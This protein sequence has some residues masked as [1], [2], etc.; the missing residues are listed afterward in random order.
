MK[1]A[2]EGPRPG[3]RNAALNSRP[4]DFI[5]TTETIQVARCQLE[6][7][8]Q[9]VFDEQDIIEIRRL[10]NGRSSWHLARELS[11]LAE[12]LLQENVV[13]QNLYVGINARK[14]PG[15][16]SAADV[17]HCRCLV[18]DFDGVELEEA[19]RRWHVAGL[20]EPSLA[21]LS[22]H[23]AH[24]YMRLQD[25]IAPEKFAELQKRLIARV[26][27]DKS[28]HDP[29]RIMRLPGTW[30]MKR[31]MQPVPCHIV[32]DDPA[33]RVELA[34]LHVLLPAPVTAP[35][36]PSK[37]RSS[38]RQPDRVYTPSTIREYLQV[39][40]IEIK[41]ERRVE[42]GTML[43][44]ARCPVNPEIVS[45]N[46][47]DI[48]VLVGD[49]GKVCYCNKHNRGQAY[50]WAD[51]RRALEGKRHNARRASFP[52]DT[53]PQPI[54]LYIEQAAAAMGCDAPFVA[55]P[56][57][58]ALAT[59]I[60]N[61]RSILI[62]RSWYEP[63]V[64]WLIVVS[65]SGTLKSPAQEAGLTFL[66]KH[67]KRAIKEYQAA[68]EDF[69]V[70][71]MQHEV[72]LKD[73]KTKGCKQ[74]Q[75]MPEEPRRPVCSRHIV[76]DTT[77]EAL[78]ARLHDQ[79]RGL[80]LVR[81]EAA[82]WLTSFD[83][84]KNGRGGDV[85]NWLE[86]HR[87]GC[88]IVDRKSGDQPTQLVQRAAVSVTGGVQPEVLERV[89]RKGHI[90]NGLAARLLLY[91]PERKPK[92]WT[93]DDVP[94]ET[95][96]LV[97]SV[98]DRLL[99]LQP[100]LNEDGDPVPV[101]VP[102]TPEARSLFIRFYD[103]HNAE[104]AELTGGIAA[105]FSKLEGYAARLALVIH[106]IRW[107][108]NDPSLLNADRIDEQ[109]MGDAIRL[110]RWFCEEAKWFYGWL[111]ADDNSRR[112]G[113]LAETIRLSGGC[114][115]VREWHRKR[116]HKTS[117]EAEAELSGLVTAGFGQWQDVPASAVGGRPTRVFVVT[118][119]RDCDKTPATPRDS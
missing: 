117:E 91:V 114:I 108:A 72:M 103:D 68:M 62:K 92:R 1:S 45:E 116:H 90:E 61:T 113:Q 8:A 37:P 119:D 93:D 5:I 6:T 13:G 115:T 67:E 104:Q 55:M 84:Y 26:N 118:G 19:L 42:G 102:M 48:G 21:I 85:Q 3:E 32:G 46:D 107:A 57:L 69:K 110:C 79:P 64:L 74:G 2:N 50:S 78:V 11:A 38:G 23:G 16:K 4:F 53:L 100:N 96:R 52:T 87:A 27:S 41:G 76:G 89:L 20:G 39:N 31:P 105:A 75:P 10:P 54:R 35:A 15:G 99:D 47:S 94:E 51:V 40:G 7:Y 60:G 56:L 58:A 28:I 86:M 29:P 63:C 44:L 70:L 33:R 34:D 81:D 95:E 12:A 77:I 98:F 59:A 97:E 82:G 66:R 43:L 65:P 73:W 101:A 22:G 25:P 106:F 80:C 71:Q 9:I 30:N 49:D 24:L 88:I 18:A 14:K 109:T 111:Q 83:Q 112:H 36:I 17:L